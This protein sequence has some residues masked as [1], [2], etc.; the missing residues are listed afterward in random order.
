MKKYVILA[1]GLSILVGLG[2]SLLIN[3]DQLSADVLRSDT[4]I[5]GNLSV[6]KSA[7][8]MDD[9]YVMRNKWAST[10]TRT[11]QDSQGFINCADGEFVI[12]VNSKTGAVKCSKL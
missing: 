7:L 8:I 6:N 9:I 3:S 2:A 10:S 5:R 11:G 12:G 4:V 1:I